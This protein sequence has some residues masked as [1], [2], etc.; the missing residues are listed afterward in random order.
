MFSF[1]IQI[2]LNNYYCIMV[3]DDKSDQ[4]KFN[5]IIIFIFIMQ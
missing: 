5:L 4:K 3:V 2:Y 1:Y